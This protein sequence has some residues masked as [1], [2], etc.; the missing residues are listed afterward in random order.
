VMGGY[1]REIGEVAKLGRWAARRWVAKSVACLLA[2]AKRYSLVVFT[3]ALESRHYQ[4]Y[5]IGKISKEVGQHS[6]AHKKKLRKKIINRP[7]VYPYHR[8][9]NR[10]DGITIF[11]PRWHT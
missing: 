4:K 2:T 10:I 11:I 6:L 5:A 9:L 8:T 3:P 1:A 7:L